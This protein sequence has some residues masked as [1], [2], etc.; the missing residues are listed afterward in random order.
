MQLILIA[1]LE[2]FV[3]LAVELIAIRLSIPVVGNSVILTG[4]MLGVIL[5]ALSAGY[6]T[7]GV[8]SSRLNQQQV[9]TK[10]QQNFLGAA[11]FYLLITFPMHEWTIK[12]GLMLFKDS[13]WAILLTSLLYV[14]PVWIASQ[15]IPLLTQLDKAQHAGEKAGKMLFFSTIGSM[16]GSTLTPILLFGHFGV[17]TTSHIL[18]GVLVVC[19]VLVLVG[20]GNLKKQWLLPVTA[21]VFVLV[22]LFSSKEHKRFDT[23]YQTLEILERKDHTLMKAGVVISSDIKTASRQP[24]SDYAREAMKVLGQD[25]NILVIGAAGFAIPQE[26]ARNPG[27]RITALDVDGAVKGVAEK[28]F[29]RE[30]LRP[31]VSFQPVGGRYFVNSTTEQYENV[32]VDAYFG[33]GIPLEL[34]TV[35][36]FQA[37]SQKSRHVAM[38]VIAD[39]SLHNRFTRGIMRTFKQVYPDAHYKL[40]TDDKLTN[41]ML[42]SASR[43]GYTRVPDFQLSPYTDDH[44]TAEH[45][46]AS[47]HH[48]MFQF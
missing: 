25:K 47:L 27:V 48:L 44:N 35:E 6:Y 38:N 12:L 40:L 39:Q 22:G 7:G 30:K 23:A 15:T 46:V 1:F 26:L 10:L 45:D 16:L 17:H 33:L 31:N 18:I 21:L 43:E 28:H 41:M 11:L 2:G 3:T 29:L 20:A 24:A 13:T 37:L 32:L 14:I 34:T 19:A 8:L 4:I 36:F 9:V 42:V 5:L